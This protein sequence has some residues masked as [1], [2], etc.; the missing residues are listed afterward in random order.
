MQF[1]QVL[2]KFVEIFTLT[3]NVSLIRKCSL[4]MGNIIYFLWQHMN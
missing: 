2:D 4:V 1:I 3:M